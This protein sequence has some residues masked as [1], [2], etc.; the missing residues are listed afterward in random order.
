MEW[1]GGQS[2]QN[3][4]IN[5]SN[6]SANKAEARLNQLVV[7]MLLSLPSRSINIHFVD[8]TFSAQ[9][10]F[11]TRNLDE[12]IYGKLISSSND[13][14]HLM[15]SLREKMAKALEEYGDVAKYN[16]SKNR[17]VVPY[18][19]VVINDYQKCVNEM[20]DLDALFENG[21][22]GGIYF[23][24]MNNLD[25]KSDRDIDSLMALKDF[26]QVL[27]AENFGNYSKDAVI[28]CT[29]ILDNPIL[30]KACF[31]Y[32]NESAELPQVA[33]T[34]VDYDK[35]LSK[36]FET[37]D[38]AMVIPVG[39][40]EN[41]EL[42]DFTIDTVSHIH[43]FIIGQSG[44]GKSV[45]LHDVIIGAM[46][47][48]SP[49]ELELYLMD[50]KIGG[51]EFN[52]YRNEKHVKALLVDNSDIQITLEILRD[53]SNKMRERGKQLRASGVSNI[54]EYNQVNPTKKMPR[55]VFIADECHVMFPT[56]NSKD[57]KLYREISE[58][59]QKI[60]KE[61][62]SQGVHLVLATQTIAQAEISSEI[63]NNI[64]DFYLLKCS[65]SDSERLV[66]GSVDTT[67]G[68]KTGQ[69]LHHDI[70]HDVVFKSTYLPTSQTLEIIKKIND[71][72]KASKNEQFYF[73][74]SQIFEI[75]DEVKN[76]LAEKGDAIAFGRSIDTKMEPVVI[77][78]RNEYADNVMLFGINDE[79]QVSRTTMAS[80]KSLRIS[81]KN[82]KIKVI[83][84]LS[85]EQR[86]T[87]KMLNDWENKG[88]IELLNPQ[89][90][91]GELVNIANSIME[92]TAEPTVLYI[93]GQERFRELRMD[94]EIAFTKPTVAADDFGFD[95]SMFTAGDSGSM[96]FNSYQKAIEYILK[97]GAE[98]GVHV[99][100]QIDKPKQLLF[101]DYMSAKDF[102]NMFHHLIMLK[103]DENAVNSLGMSDD[104]KLENLSSDIER[105][106]AIYYNETNN[107]YTLF[108][109]FD[110]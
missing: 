91:G 15:D 96:N 6:K 98:V 45:F 21:H 66:R 33:V 99:I 1:M 51:V 89:N 106:R 19:V 12:K 78:L 25:F 26:Y 77:P 4:V 42:V 60:A 92:R 29:P 7:D 73:V 38:K 82:I 52:R 41:G 48:Y 24:L 95:S 39:S 14:N 46:A 80:I 30:A 28:R 63:L 62:R 55:I 50:F 49:D 47:K 90:C 13:W 67:S 32:I 61:G 10:S 72:T 23:I 68:L 104:L 79:E 93:L 108:T 88:E 83:N 17:V 69:V 18:D 110:F 20:S 85:A 40:S 35:I 43:C 84:C 70:D 87:T 44:T 97:N 101:S 86:N 16:D 65:P 81:N 34:S 59:L 31:N 8:L 57:T 2:G 103:S 56:M 5:Y 22:K 9:A 36:G 27:E 94:M 71:K 109:P 102:F 105:L 11:L 75:D 3:F 74:G 76:L 54:V 107:S 58:I 37:I 53:I 64:S 100:L